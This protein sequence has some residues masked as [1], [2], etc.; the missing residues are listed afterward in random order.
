MRSFVFLEITTLCKSSL[1]HITRVRL[2]PCVYSHVAGHDV[3]LVEGHGAV[4]ILTVEPFFSSVGY[5]GVGKVIDVHL[6]VPK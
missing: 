3:L 4:R 2:D 5:L 1:T 6:R